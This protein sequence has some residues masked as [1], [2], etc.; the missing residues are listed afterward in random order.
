MILVES[1]EGKEGICLGL[2]E[3]G[4]WFAS[5]DSRVETICMEFKKRF[6]VAGEMQTASY[7]SLGLAVGAGW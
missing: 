4:R 5:P 3:E 1:H 7:D 6:W 2:E